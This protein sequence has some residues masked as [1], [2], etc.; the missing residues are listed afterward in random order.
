MDGPATGDDTDEIQPPLV[1]L[2]I[3]GYFDEPLLTELGSPDEANGNSYQGSSRSDPNPLMLSD[4]SNK[5][6]LWLL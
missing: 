6:L 2:E 3:D 4:G 1:C 5:V